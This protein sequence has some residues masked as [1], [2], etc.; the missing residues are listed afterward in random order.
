MERYVLLEN[1]HVFRNCE[2]AIED[3]SQRI[4]SDS[5]N[6]S[7]QS[8]ETDWSYNP[9]LRRTVNRKE[10]AELYADGFPVVIRYEKDM[11]SN[12]LMC[13]GDRKAW[14][15]RIVIGVNARQMPLLDICEIREKLKHE[16]GHLRQSYCRRDR[17][18]SQDRKF[19]A[20]DYERVFTVTDKETETV[21]YDIV[22]EFMYI[23]SPAEMQQRYNELHQHMQDIPQEELEREAGYYRKRNLAVVRFVELTDDIHMLEHMKTNL[24]QIHNALAAQEVWVPLVLAYYFKTYDIWKTADRIS[25]QTVQD[26]LDET[27]P[28]SRVH[29]LAAKFHFWL[30]QTVV[31]QYRHHVF[32]IIHDVLHTRLWEFED[33]KKFGTS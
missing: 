16:F 26:Y 9:E 30:E 1:M 24:M 8:W 19:V 22:D 32:S 14:P 18:I 7:M 21:L 27:I 17:D 10:G 11:P 15:D 33:Y 3:I 13:V 12:N 2:E 31:R 4:F 5:R 28:E 29:R 6:D 20:T 23:Y 25:R